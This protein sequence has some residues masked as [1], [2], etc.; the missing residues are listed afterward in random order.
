M[1]LKIFYWIFLA[2][3]ILLG[4]TAIAFVWFHL[5]ILFTLKINKNGIKAK[6]SRDRIFN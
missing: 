6:N 5:F 1:I 3:F 4:M 2:N